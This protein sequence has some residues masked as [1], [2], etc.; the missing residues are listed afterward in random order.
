[1]S[2]MITKTLIYG[3]GGF[4]RE[5]AWLMS[6]SIG[7]TSPVAF[8]DDNPNRS[9]T[10]MDLPVVSFEKAKQDYSEFPICIAIATPNVKKLLADKIKSNNLKLTHVVHSSVITHYSSTIGTGSIV[11][12][13]NLIMPDVA[14]GEH[15]HINLACTIGHDCEIGDYSTISPGVHISGNVKIGKNVFIGTGV[16]IIQGTESNPIVIEDGTIIGAGACITQSTEKDGL[17]VGVPA[18]NKR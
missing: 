2:R 18:K 12:A 9:E 16:N 5:T 4:A 8:I 6:S 3:A 13:G 7:Q 14:I 11:C 1:M 17:Y 15:V 10:L